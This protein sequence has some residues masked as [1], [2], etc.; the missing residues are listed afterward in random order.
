[1]KTQ[2]MQSNEEKTIE[3]ASQ[4]AKPEIHE[5]PLS[6]EISTYSNAELPSEII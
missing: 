5:I 2:L 1:M 6:C 3:Q 4:W